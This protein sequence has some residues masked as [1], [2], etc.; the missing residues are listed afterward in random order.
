MAEKTEEER[1][2]FLTWSYRQVG[3]DISELVTNSGRGAI[4]VIRLE[5]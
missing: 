5:Y 4:T 2:R 3:A 1:E